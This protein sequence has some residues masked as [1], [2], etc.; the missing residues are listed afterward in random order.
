MTL[1]TIR[2][3]GCWVIGGRRTIAGRTSKC[4][5]CRRQRC[6]TNEQKIADLP[7]DRLE[8]SPPFTFCAVDYFG[9]W[10]V[11]EGRRDVKRYGVLFTW[12]ASRAIHLETANSLDASSFLNAYRRFVGH[13]RPVRQLRSDRGTNFVGGKSELQKALS[14]M[15][16]GKITEALLKKNCDYVEVQMNVPHAS[17]MGGVWERQIRTA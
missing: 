9:P 8:P 17:H 15:D 10:H 16:H 1:N 13:R 2:S 5:K 7:Q 12:M 6:P 14:E 4:V 11:K 3:A